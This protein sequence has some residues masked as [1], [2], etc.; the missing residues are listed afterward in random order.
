MYDLSNGFVSSVGDPPSQWKIIRFW[1]NFVHNSKSWTRWQPGDH[2]QFQNSRWRAAAIFNILFG[3]NS[4]AHCS[5]SVKFCVEKQFFFQNFANETD[6][7]FH[8]T[9]FLFSYNA[10]NVG[11]GERR[12]SCR[13]LSDILAC[14]HGDKN[15]ARISARKQLRMHSPGVSSINSWLALSFHITSLTYV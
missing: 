13:L 4:A 6:T 10:V 9:Y 8:R 2:E 11:F 3:H 14:L 5:T 1:W 12:L 15:T 7:A